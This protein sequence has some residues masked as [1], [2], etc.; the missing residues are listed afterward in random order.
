MKPNENECLVKLNVTN[1]IFGLLLLRQAESELA[2][3]FPL[4][5]SGC[6]L[7]WQSAIKYCMFRVRQTQ[8]RQYFICK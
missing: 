3:T 6:D 5:T 7:F 2:F 4:L 8:E 1:D